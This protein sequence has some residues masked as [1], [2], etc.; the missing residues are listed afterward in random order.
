MPAAPWRG[1]TLLLCCACLC[2]ALEQRDCVLGEVGQPVLLPCHPN[3][4]RLLNFSVE[5]RDRDRAVFRSR[6]DG[7]GN[8]ETWSV[9]YARIPTDAATTGNFSLEL[10]S[11][12]PEHDLGRYSL[13]LLSGENQSAPLCT[14]C[15]RVAASFRIPEVSKLESSY[16]CRS[17]G[18]YPQPAVYWLINDSRRPPNGSVSTRAQALPDSHLFNFTSQLTVNVSKDDTVSCT[19]K[20]PSTN[21]TLTVKLRA[22]TSGSRASQGMWIFSTV[23]CVVVAVMVLAGIYY[24]IH[25]DK[26][27]K[28]RK[29]EYEEPRRGRRYQYKQATEEMMPEPEETDV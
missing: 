27:S 25:L 14:R 22:S 20:N 9:N 13:F 7:D 5:W 21:E 23:L 2:A 10:P 16:L 15:L 8:V 19:V 11:A 29:K 17:W 3:L 18:G 6:W 4:G 28:R 26:I 12:R 1:A 24:Q